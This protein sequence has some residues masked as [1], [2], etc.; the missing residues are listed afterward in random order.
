MSEGM[1]VEEKVQEEVSVDR[2]AAFDLFEQAASMGEYDPDGAVLS[3]MK[4]PPDQSL[5]DEWEQKNHQ[6]YYVIFPDTD[7]AFHPNVDVF[8]C[9][10]LLYKESKAL[11]MKGGMQNSTMEQVVLKCTLFPR[12]TLSQL[13][14]NFPS[15][16]VFT[17]YK[18]IQEA[19][20]WADAT[21]VSKN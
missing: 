17:L 13:N 1:L 11:A 4:E 5:L 15:G 6:N 9:R 2:Q 3:W 7:G 19:S 20:G 18:R 14:G 16:Y 10:K 8:I 21:L 12:L